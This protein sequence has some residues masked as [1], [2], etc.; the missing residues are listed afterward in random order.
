MTGAVWALNFCWI[1]G[2]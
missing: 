2:C 1:W